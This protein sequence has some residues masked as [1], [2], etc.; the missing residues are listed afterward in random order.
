[1]R[2]VFIPIL[3]L[4]LATAW[5]QPT[6]PTKSKP[7]D[8][9]FTKVVLDNDLNEPM[10]VAVAADG[11][12]YYIERPG[13]VNRWS[14]KT[15]RKTQLA[16]V[17]VRFQAED[18]LMG[19][20]LDPKFTENH[21]LYLY[22]GDPKPQANGGYVN[23]LSRFVVEGDSLKLSSRKDLLQVPLLHEGVNHSGGSLAFDRAGNLYLST[24]DNTNPF[25]SEG[26]SPTDDRPGRERFDAMRS[27]GNTNDLR[28]KILRIHPKPDGSYTIPAGNLFP[29]GT[30]NGSG[31]TTRSGVTRP[32]IY[33]MG[34]RNPYRIDVDQRTGALYWGEVGADA[35]KDRDDRGPRG[36]DEFNRAAKAGN[37]GWPLLVGNN[38]PYH[39][40]DFDKKQPLGVVDPK[41]PLNNSRNNTGLKELPPAQPA[42][43]W[44]PYDASPEFPELGIG[45]RNAIGGPVYYSGDYQ[46]SER[47]FPAYYDGKWFIADWMRN[48]IFTASMDA[49]GK[50]V[51]LERF[52]PTESFSK[53]IDMT[54]GPD[55]AM[56]LLEYGEYWRTKN[57][58]AKLVRIE[59]TEGNRAP[60]ARLK[61]DRVVG[62]APLKVRFSARQ[63]FDY[64]KADS[65]RYQWRFTGKSVQ[66]TGQEAAFTFT[67][68][69]TYNVSLTVLD[70]AGK[71][72]VVQ[73]QIRVG[74]E[75]PAVAI[76]WKGNRSF[77]F[78]RGPINYAVRV[79]DKEDGTLGR[80]IPASKVQ[81]SLQHLREG[82]D[83]AGLAAAGE[84]KPRG[85]QLMEASDCMA[86]HA[87]EKASVGPSFVAISQKYDQGGEA[88]L[89]QKVIQG[90]GGVWGKDHVM[91]AHPQLSNDQAAEMVRYILSIKEEPPQL[92]TTGTVTLPEQ[93][94]LYQL[95]ARYTD[96]GGLVGQSSLL[97]REPRVPVAQA[98][99]VKGVGRRNAALGRST[100][101]FNESGASLAFDDLDLTG[102]TNISARF[103]AP[104]LIGALEIRLDSPTGTLIGAIPVDAPD[105]EQT[106]VATIQPTQGMHTVYLVYKEKSGGMSIWKRLEMLWVEFME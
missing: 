103:F 29:V 30:A 58:D 77:Y 95:T 92:K 45:G 13:L 18:G 41:K 104:G 50:L 67:K 27:S 26:Y 28:G 96:K 89:T 100:M 32:E 65:L 53:P 21:W 52:L 61:A 87:K 37:F 85:Q 59:Y 102:I 73:Q 70:P 25:E 101:T 82:Y 31:Q 47:K 94:G 11:A 10:E 48:W 5:A 46:A 80:P 79:T 86:C 24:G 9:R 88:S 78:D 12:V 66:A 72:A 3:L 54:F 105:K 98:R 56:Y 38:K 23:V 34:L 22:Y 63:S 93:A 14:P 43:I 68:P 99:E 17:P 64:D 83:F 84:L 76:D 75:P 1:M 60:I 4:S 62:A 71:S 44:Y 51:A 8:S 33:V 19:L 90:G 7:D 16:K 36:H 39:Y 2:F 40:L 97:L 81:V 74:N 49:E 69:G 15:G 57:T 6:K 55:G 42:F 106:A 91:S 20:A 35:G